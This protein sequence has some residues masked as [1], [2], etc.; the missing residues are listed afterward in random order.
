M[1]ASGTYIVVYMLQPQAIGSYFDRSRWPLHIT[2]L[3]WFGI[4]PSKRDQFR[5]EMEQ[6]ERTKPALKAT[7]GEAA[8]FG[9]E[10]NVPVNIIADQGELKSLHLSLLQIA[11]L[12]QL[13][14]VDTSWVNDQYIAHITERTG[15]PHPEPGDNLSIDGFYI[16]RLVDNALC[17]VVSY[18]QLRGAN[19]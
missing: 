3:P 9:S 14:L 4:A 12:L 17:Q 11:H 18:H 1:Q 2:L 7:I 10:R 19:G 15:Y 13:P 8:L 16:V 6:L 5:Y